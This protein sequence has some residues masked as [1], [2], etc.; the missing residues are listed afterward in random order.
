MKLSIIIPVY[1][2]KNTIVEILRRCLA[3]SLPQGMDREI[4]VVNDG[5]KDGTSGELKAYE[6]HS[7]V[8]VFHLAANFGK[9]EAVKLGISRAQGDIILIQDADLEYD[10]TH[11]PALLEP[12]LTG[13][14]KVVFG[15]RFLGKI[16][17]MEWINWL[18]NRISVLTINLFFHSKLTDFHTCYKVIKA[19]V[20]KSLSLG[21]KNFVIDTEIP[22]MLLQQGYQIQEVPIQYV[23]RSRQEGKKITWG[24]ALEAYFFL[25][26]EGFR[27]KFKKNP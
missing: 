15:S 13:S 10:P 27:G 18:A 21:T 8:R 2:E 16:E 3:V 20:L 4:I 1:N 9:S 6:S 26:K 14:T 7:Q 11:Y 23:A 25:L 19:D 12:I 22:V 24:K 17:R 5:S